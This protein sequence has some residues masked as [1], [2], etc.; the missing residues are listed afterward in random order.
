VPA[1]GKL[2]Q[3]LGAA[4]RVGMRGR[5]ETAGIVALG[6]PGGLVAQARSLDIRAHAGCAGEKRDIDSGLVHH[7]DVLIEIEQHPVHDEARC[8]V[9]VIGDELAASQI[10]RH[11]LARGEV[12]LEIDDHPSSPAARSC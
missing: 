3:R 11:E 7:P 5:D 9:L 6:S 10:L 1:A 2:A 12:V 8:A 4:E